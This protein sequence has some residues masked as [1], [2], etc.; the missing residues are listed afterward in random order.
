M[1]F[2]TGSWP[3]YTDLH[4]LRPADKTVNSSRGTKDY[5]DGG[6]PHSEAVLCE[7]DNNSWE[8]PDEVK[9]DIARGIFYMA[10]RY[11]GDKANEPDL[12]LVEDVD[13]TQP[14]TPKLGQLSARIK[15]HQAD[16]VD[17]AERARNQKIFDK[18]QGNRNPFI[19]HPEWLGMIWGN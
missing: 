4:H 15:W 3:A 13:S 14:G 8:P 16:P 9:G 10:V 18:Y 7:S 19:D 17:D 1:G 11:E 6:N 5:D 2:P 12:E